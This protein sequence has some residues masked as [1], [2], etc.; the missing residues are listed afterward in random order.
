MTKIDYL[1]NLIPSIFPQTVLRT[2][3]LRSLRG[4]KRRSNLEPPS[5]PPQ[6]A[7]FLAMTKIDYLLVI[8]NAYRDVGDTTPWTGSVDYVRN[9]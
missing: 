6:I 5:M 7:S 9:I 2:T 1:L 3:A 4:V 8:A